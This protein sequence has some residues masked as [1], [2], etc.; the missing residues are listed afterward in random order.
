MSQPATKPN[1]WILI[2]C[3][4]IFLSIPAL[5]SWL[6]RMMIPSAASDGTT[7]G[8]LEAAGQFGD[9]YG[10]LTCL[11]ALAAGYFTYQTL[12]AQRKQ[13]EQQEIANLLEQRERHFFRLLEDFKDALEKHRWENSEP[14][15][16]SQGGT[17]FTLAEVMRHAKEVQ[18]DAENIQGDKPEKIQHFCEHFSARDF[19]SHYAFGQVFRKFIVLEKYLDTIMM[20]SAPGTH[21]LYHQTLMAAMSQNE[22]RLLAFF[23]INYNVHRKAQKPFDEVF[24]FVALYCRDLLGNHG[25]ITEPYFA[26]DALCGTEPLIEKIQHLRMLM[27]MK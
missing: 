11:A 4:L 12:K 8:W 3:A 17:A 19:I 16:L 15:G 2:P 10:F 7:P 13:L 5:V 9:Q 21:N 22:M 24:V 20:A 26:V 14:L 23:W 18:F 6:I 25:L 27:G 1:F